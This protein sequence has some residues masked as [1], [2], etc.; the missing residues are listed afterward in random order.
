MSLDAIASER[1]ESLRTDFVAPL[2]NPALWTVLHHAQTPPF[3]NIESFGWNQPGVRRAAWSLLQTVLA[4]CKGWLP[5]VLDMSYHPDDV[6][7]ALLD[8]LLQVL[9][10]AIL[11]SAWVEPDPNVRTAM[12]QP[13][14]TF[15][16][17]IVSLYALYL[18]SSLAEHPI[19]WDL[20]AKR[21][22]EDEGGDGDEEDDSGA[23][24]DG[25]PHEVQ[26]DQS[27]DSVVPL[28]PSPAYREFLQ[29]LE[30]G[31]S[32]SPLQGYPTI[33]VIISTIPPSVRGSRSCL[34]RTLFS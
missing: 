16:R 7:I 27:N 11:R 9:S 4:K 17:G 22:K 1:S 32:G 25:Q 24:E 28:V 33:I 20:D 14:L 13:L 15:L 12:W 23:E 2:A 31:C 6:S 30:L 3:V 18:G 26:A 21:F 8:P 5:S 29:F 34:L 19:A 10:S